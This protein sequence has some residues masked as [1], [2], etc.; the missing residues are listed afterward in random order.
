VF[1]GQRGGALK[2]RIDNPHQ[3]RVR[4]LTVNPRMM[5]PHAT[6]PEDGDR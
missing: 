5:P 6:G 1:V 2:I 3:R 4:Q